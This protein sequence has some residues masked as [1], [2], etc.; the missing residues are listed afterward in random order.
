MRERA[1]FRADSC[2][3]WDIIADF[4]LAEVCGEVEELLSEKGFDKDILE[5]G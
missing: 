2:W 4:V 1:L 3:T 5:I